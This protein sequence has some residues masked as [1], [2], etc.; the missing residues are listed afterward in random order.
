[1]SW[2]SCLADEDMASWRRVVCSTGKVLDG[3]VAISARWGDAGGSA[4]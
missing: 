2:R 3:E 4:A 1:M